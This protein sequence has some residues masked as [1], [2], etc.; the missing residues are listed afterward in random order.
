MDKRLKFSE[1]E[2]ML[3]ER[4][5]DIYS[6]LLSQSI[7]SADKKIKSILSR[8]VELKKLK[9]NKYC[10]EL[11]SKGIRDWDEAMTYFY[12]LRSISDKLKKVRWVHKGLIIDEKGDD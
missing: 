7:D 11:W 5:V 9:G 12:V 4:A 8:D 3:I 2:T 1:E 10:E 6:G